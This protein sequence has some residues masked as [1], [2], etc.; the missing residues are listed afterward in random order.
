LQ[1]NLLAEH[2]IT[3]ILR[4]VDAIASHL[5]IPEGQQREVK[6]LEK[7]VEPSAVLEALEH[8]EKIDI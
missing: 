2:E 3:R 8:R 4:S 7:D 5:K 6:E 1:F